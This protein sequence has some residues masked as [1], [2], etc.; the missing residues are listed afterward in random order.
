MSTAK[1]DRTGLW[2]F[3]GALIALAV[4]AMPVFVPMGPTAFMWYL[5]SLMAAQILL[6]AVVGFVGSRIVSNAI[7]KYAPK[8]QQFANKA[9]EDLGKP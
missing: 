9:L 2:M 6:W 3:V 5:G 7:D 1:K 8:I 4:S